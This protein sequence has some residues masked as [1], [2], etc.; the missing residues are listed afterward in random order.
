MQEHIWQC[1]KISVVMNVFNVHIN[2]APY[3]GKIVDSYY[4]EGRFLDA[5]SPRAS[6]ENEQMGLVVDLA[7]GTRVVF[8]QIAG[9]VARRILC[10]SS[11]GDFLERGKR[12]GMIRFG[13]RVDVFLPEGM[14]ILVKVGQPTVA[15]ETP[16]A[17][18]V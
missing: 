1:Q 5:R 11:V 10:Y 15:G 2:R 8:V 6:S 7:N 9:L 16:I 4:R 3:S 17:R 18:V 12:Y 14:E 13:S